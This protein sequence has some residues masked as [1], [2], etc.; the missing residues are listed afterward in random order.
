VRALKTFSA[1]RINESR[2]SIGK[3]VWQSRFY[4]CIIHDNQSLQRIRNYIE[5]NPVMWIDD[6]F[7]KWRI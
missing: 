4:D 7:N 1:R 6:M 2:N 5:R 3:S